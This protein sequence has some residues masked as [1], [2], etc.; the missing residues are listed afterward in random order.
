VRR[1]P[2]IASA[3]LAVGSAT[4]AFLAAIL[5]DAAGLDT[6]A[7]SA[8]AAVVVTAAY[9][10]RP[11]DGL[12]GFGLLLLFTGTVA[13]WTGVDVRYGDEIGVLLL[14][15][16]TLAL[17]RHRLVPPR[18]GWREA[19]LA[20][21]FGAGIVS[22]LVHGVP[23]Q[24]WIPGLAL[25]A[26]TFV[27]LYLVM[28]VRVTPD[29]VRRVSTVALGV[30]LVILGVGVVELLAPA[31]VSG[32]LGVF[33]FDRKRG[34]IE[35][36]NSW[37]THPALYGW[38]AAFASLFLLARFAVLRRTWTLV[39]GVLLGGAALISGRRTPV[40]SLVI[41]LG[42]GALHQVVASRTPWRAWAAIGAG[43]LLV[44]VVSVPV[45][46][47]FYA[48]TFREYFGR[49]AR[50]MEVFEENPR[51]RPIMELH[52]R[53]A[54]YAGSLA[55][56]RDEL[57]L[58]VGIGRY[59]SHMSREEYSPVYQQYKLHRVFGLRERRPI[60]V[61][62]TF[63]PMVLGETGVI[64]F[65]GALG[66]FALLGRDLWRAAVPDGSPEATAFT[67]G[68]LMVFTEALVRSAAAP[69]FL[70]PPIAYWVF[71]AAGL[72][73]ALRASASANDEASTT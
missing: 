31:G 2:V 20:V 36:V 69:V 68:A 45:M 59:G 24:V 42:V 44:A 18:P 38:L 10:I 26:K 47:E 13:F 15:T 37:F 71:G 50:I 40:I 66:F 73:L 34:P 70:A 43:A 19:A 23:A 6:V 48:R 30:A 57:P 72:A 53:V 65:A 51:A 9:A 41:S 25:L 33:P 17:H 46:G 8:A 62:D 29:E 22:S 56:A 63:W 54:L 67:L 4:L 55:I 1:H 5:V 35:V 21:F 12:L 14:V 60:A 7:V 39:L 3:V 52:P 49:P 27:F 64:G 11:V 28:S 58:G 32:A 16:T 61:T